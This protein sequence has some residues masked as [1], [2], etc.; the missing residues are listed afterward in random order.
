MWLPQKEKVLSPFRRESEATATNP[1]KL[2]R[3]YVVNVSHPTAGE[4]QGRTI[5]PINGSRIAVLDAD[6][7]VA[8]QREIQ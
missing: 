4:F 1:A 3:F 2:G 8:L 6:T 7:T 5:L